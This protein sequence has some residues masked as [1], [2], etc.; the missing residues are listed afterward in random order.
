MVNKLIN[1]DYVLQGTSIV[2][3]EGVQA[4]FADAVFRLQVRRGSF[5]F[6]PELGS[7]LWQLGRERPADWASCARQACLEALQGTGVSLESIRVCQEG[8]ALLVELTLT[9]GTHSME[10]EVRV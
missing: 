2:R 8:Q 1:G 6:L 7:R 9:L 4:I 10:T 5:P 3:L